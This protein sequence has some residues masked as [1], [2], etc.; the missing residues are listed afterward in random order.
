MALTYSLKFKKLNFYNKV[1]LEKEGE[2]VID[3]LSFR[4]KGK[5]A[6]DQ[7]EVVYFG[8]MK[9]LHIK[10]DLLSFSTYKKEKYALSDFSNLFEVF[11]KDFMRVRNEYLADSLFM[12]VGMLMKEFEGSVDLENTHG[13]IVPKGKC[14][15]QFYEGSIVIMPEKRDCF[16]IYLGLLKGHDF[17]DLEYVLRLYL[18]TGQNV[19]ISKLGTSFEDVQETMESIMGKMYEK[20]MNGFNEFLPGLDAATLVKLIYLLKGGR[21]VTI[22][23]L[24]KVHEELPE[25]VEEFVFGEN[26]GMKEKAMMLRKEGGE[27]NFFYSLSVGKSRETG[28]LFLRTWFMQA[29]PEKNMVAVGRTSGSNDTT[30]HFFRIIM[31]QGDPAEKL[32]AKILEI[33]QS[34]LIFRYD[35]SVVYKSR[36]DL[37]KSK[38]RTALKRMSFLRLLRKSYMGYSKAADFKQFKK[39]FAVFEDKARLQTRTQQE[40]VAA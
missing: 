10:D 12:K 26:E 22:K 5:G 16:A 28:D 7:G 34:M 30:L 11:L 32:K 18:D 21:F 38:F 6:Q 25:K 40:P 23:Q 36:R 39:D 27:E 14:K 1:L 19:Y 9:D 29:L 2:I 15:I 24:K 8:D 20:V 35:F 17:D 13:K 33:D 37:R 3:R 31:Q 4:L